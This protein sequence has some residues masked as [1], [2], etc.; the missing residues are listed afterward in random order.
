MNE[1][2]HGQISQIRSSS[3]GS[4]IYGC[5]MPDGTRIS[6]VDTLTPHVVHSGSHVAQRD[7]ARG[8]VKQRRD[9][10]ASDETAVAMTVGNLYNSPFE[11]Q[12][13]EARAQL[14]TIQRLLRDIHTCELVRVLSV[15]PV[16]D[17]VGFVEI[18]P[19]LLD[20]DTSNVVIEQAPIFNAPYFRYQGGISAVVLDPVAGDIGIAIFS[21]RDI[22]NIKQTLTNGAPATARTYSM[23]DALYIGGVLNGAPTQFVKFLPDGGGI[24]I[25]SPA[26]ISISTPGDVHFTAA[27]VI[28][29]ANVVFNGTI[30]STTAGAGANTFAGTIT[31]PDAIINGVT[32]STHK[33]TGVQTG[34]GTSGGPTN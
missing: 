22:T 1:V 20:V 13:D 27:T 6:P 9:C 32:Q 33:H 16:S 23:A 7:H 34:G 12:F 2:C 10:W 4:R 26:N 30:S 25:E 21:E 31:A 15:N 5:R 28:F 29:D 17:R 19:L 24:E 11:A 18:Q 8:S 3:V 14:F